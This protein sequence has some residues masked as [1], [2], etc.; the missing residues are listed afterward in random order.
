MSLEMQK[1]L[2]GRQA[3][4]KPTKEKAAAFVLVTPVLFRDN[5]RPVGQG[6]EQGYFRLSLP[7]KSR[8]S[9][10]GSWVVYLEIPKQGWSLIV[11]ADASS[12]PRLRSLFYPRDFTMAYPASFCA[13]EELS[14][15]GHQLI[16]SSFDPVKGRGR[17][18]C[19]IAVEPNRDY[20]WNL[21]PDGTYISAAKAEENPIHIRRTDGQPAHD[22]TIKGWPGLDYMDFSADSKG[23][24]IRSYSNGIGTLL[25]L[26]P[27]GKGHPLWQPKSPIVGWGMPSR[28]GRQLA[29]RGDSEVDPCAETAE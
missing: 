16:F 9:P 14:A 7:I 17:E 24:F 26:D 11:A 5:S 8:V 4:S 19:R 10:D 20:N 2:P 18:L 29:I 28:D 22:L 23:L 21:S 12:N 3:Q 1:L 13:F 6:G 27:S 15:D 25:Y